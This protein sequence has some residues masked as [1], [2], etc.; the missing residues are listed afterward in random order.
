M[1]ITIAFSLI[2][3]IGYGL[4][5]IFIFYEVNYEKISYF[6][7]SLFLT[8]LFDIAFDVIMTCIFIFFRVK[9]VKKG[10]EIP[11]GILKLF[12]MRGFYIPLERLLLLD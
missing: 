12:S 8:W 7:A 1:I 5:N 3:Q 10:I 4:A 9:S 6:V 2:V 11:L